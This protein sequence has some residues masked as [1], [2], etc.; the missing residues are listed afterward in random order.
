MQATEP[1]GKA[2]PLTKV[3][4]IVTCWLRTVIFSTS[5]GSRQSACWRLIYADIGLHTIL[6]P[7]L[8]TG[9]QVC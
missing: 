3:W 7:R 4:H 1:L 2:N 5:H 6:D 8:Q 9:V